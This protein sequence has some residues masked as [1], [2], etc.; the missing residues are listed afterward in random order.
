MRY[1]AVSIRNGTLNGPWQQQAIL[2]IPTYSD[3]SVIY[4]AQ[5][6]TTETAGSVS[7]T[8]KYYGDVSYNDGRY[9][10]VSGD[11]MTGNLTA[12]SIFI[13]TGDPTLKIYSGKITDATSDGNIC[14]Q[15]SIDNT[16]GQSHTYPT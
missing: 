7:T 16:D 12:P 10:N 1:S 4:L 6:T 5:M 3:S 2:F 14:L 8:V 15:T 13:K 9:V 11:T